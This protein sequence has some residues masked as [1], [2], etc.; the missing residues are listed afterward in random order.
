M[1]CLM[2]SR[3]A[4]FCGSAIATVRLLSFFCCEIGTILNDVAIVSLTMSVSSDGIA[5]SPSRTTFIPNCSPSALSTWSSVAR[6]SRVA[7]LPIISLSER[8]CSSRTFHRPS[9]SRYPMSTRIVP[10]RRAMQPPFRAGENV[11]E[12][13]RSGPS[14]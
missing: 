6:P 13:P 7:T 9:S 1:N 3:V 8:F 4:G 14:T 11:S 10:S 2:L 5:M 12:R